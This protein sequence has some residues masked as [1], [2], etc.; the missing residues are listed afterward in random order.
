MCPMGQ[1]KICSLKCSCEDTSSQTK[2]KKN[3]Y[4]LERAFLSINK[5]L[6]ICLHIAHL[7]K[8]DHSTRKLVI[9][10]THVQEVFNNDCF[11]YLDAEYS[12]YTFQIVLSDPLN[13]DKWGG[14]AGFIHDIVYQNHLQ[15]HRD[16]ANIE[17]HL[18][19]PSYI[20]KTCN[21]MLLG[22]GVKQEQIAFDEF[23]NFSF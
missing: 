13:N 8:I 10:M 1:I 18:C 2:G 21:R 7:L 4:H 14:H 20:I 11:K 19:G 6:K 22:I 17:F 16:L 23:N 12:N 15:N 9:S 3:L 5:R